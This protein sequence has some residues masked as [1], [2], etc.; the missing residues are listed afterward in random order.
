MKTKMMIAAVAAATFVSGAALAAG[1]G[2]LTLLRSTTS[3]RY[4]F[5]TSSEDCLFYVR[6]YYI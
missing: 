2:F 6:Y 3:S 1:K 5:P 4:V